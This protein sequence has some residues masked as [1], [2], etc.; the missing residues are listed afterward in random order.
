MDAAYHCHTDDRWV[1][2]ESFFFSPSRDSASLDLG[3]LEHLSFSV[4][5][6]FCRALSA[7]IFIYLCGVI[8]R[9]LHGTILKHKVYQTAAV[10][11]WN[12]GLTEACWTGFGV[13]RISDTT[14]DLSPMISLIHVRSAVTWGY[15]LSSL[16]FTGSTNNSSLHFY[17]FTQYTECSLY[18]AF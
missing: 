10:S 4:N 1:E 7:M 6:Y 18:I 3:H 13:Y 9:K 12:I 14:W 16:A 2:M 8:D 15:F 5:T 11:G 17:S